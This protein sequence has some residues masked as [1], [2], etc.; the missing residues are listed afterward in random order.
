M[1]RVSF[2]TAKICPQQQPTLRVGAKLAAQY[3]CVLVSPNW[4][5]TQSFDQYIRKQVCLT[6]ISS[7]FF[8][9]INRHCSGQCT[10]LS[11]TC[12]AEKT[13]ARAGFIRPQ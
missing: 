12:S 8:G 7:D 10:S 13:A 4:L 5:K 11:P 6:W 3:I 1:F 2:Y 9:E